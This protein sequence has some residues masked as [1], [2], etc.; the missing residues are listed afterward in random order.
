MKKYKRIIALSDVHGEFELLKEL[1]ENQIR[2][3]P[4]TDK[5]IMI[6][7]FFDRGRNSKQVV[8]YIKKLKKQ[9]PEQ[10]VLLMGSHEDLAY[11][12]LMNINDSY[13][14]GDPMKLWLINGGQATIDSF[15]GLKKTRRELIPFIEN[16]QLYFETRTH[17]FVHGGIPKG[18]TLKTAS[19]QEL[20]WDRDLNYKGKKTLVV[21]HTPHREV[22]TIGN[23]VCIDTA[24]FMSGKLSAYDCLNRKVYQA[25]EERE[26]E[27][28][29]RLY[30]R[31][32]HAIS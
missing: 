6:G 28:S 15:G 23:I 11:H 17:I 19:P 12:A 2:F 18:K 26:P 20:L 7:D 14:L 27:K 24:A 3:N 9:Y 16:L 5:L 10:I 30:R 21:G 29:L 4:S 8:D 1:V 22:T 31:S 32:R 13:Y 25:I